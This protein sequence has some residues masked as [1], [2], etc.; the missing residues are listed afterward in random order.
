M[1]ACEQKSDFKFVLLFTNH[2]K[3][4]LRRTCVMIVNSSGTWYVNVSGL[5]T[6]TRVSCRG[7]SHR[8]ATEVS[9]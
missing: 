5:S 4:E 7:H 8:L 2:C 9:L 6:S 3:V 1:V